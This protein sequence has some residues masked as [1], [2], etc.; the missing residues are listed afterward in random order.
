MSVPSPQNSIICSPHCGPHP[1]SNLH[2]ALS[3]LVL[4]PCRASALTAPFKLPADDGRNEAVSALVI[5]R[6]EVPKTG[7]SLVTQTVKNLPAMQETRARFL[8][9][10]DA[11]E[12]G[13]ATHFC[14]L[15]CKIP[16]TEEPGGAT[17][18]GVA[19]ELYTS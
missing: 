15:A 3:G 4:G 12:E 14:I 17:V 2:T 9:W 1:T 16:W 11:L 5:H 10:E 13:V 19:Q 7:A 8:G 18:H 6:S